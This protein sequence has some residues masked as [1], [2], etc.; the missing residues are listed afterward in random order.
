[1]QTPTNQNGRVKFVK[2]GHDYLIIEGSVNGGAFAELGMSNKSP[3]IDSRPLLVA[4]QA[5]VREYRARY[6]DNGAPSSGWS[7]VAKV[8]VGP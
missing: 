6:Y 1:M 4:G 3:F 8:T 5:E 7:D 2:K